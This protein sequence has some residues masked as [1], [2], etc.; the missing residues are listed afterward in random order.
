MK[1]KLIAVL[2][3]IF[4]LHCCLGAC[5]T[6]KGESDVLM[7]SSFSDKSSILED[8][9]SDAEEEDLGTIAI[10][11]G[12]GEV[13]PYVKKAKEYLQAEEGRNVAHYVGSY[14]NP[15]K[16]IELA[17][18]CDAKNVESYTLC[19]GVKGCAEIE[20]TQLDVGKLKNYNLYNLYKGTEYE[21]SVTANLSNGKS[22]SANAN[23]KTTELGPRVMQI[24]GIYNTRDLGGY[25]TSFGKTTKQGLIYRGGALTPYMEGGVVVYPSELTEE[26]KIYMSKTLGI[27]SDLDLRGAGAEAGNLEVSPI[28]GAE[29]Y[30][31]RIGGYGAAFEMTKEFRTVFLLLSDRASYPMYIHCTGGAD[32]T[33]T[34]SFLLNA[35][36][37][38]SEEDLVRD[39]EFTTFSRYGQRNTQE[40]EFA[41]YFQDFIKKLK[42]YEGETLAQKTEA[43]A[44][45][46]G[47]TQEEIDSIREIFLGE[48]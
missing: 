21:W 12:T 15:A 37:G 5:G 32:R 9:F 43:Y 33:G 36:L 27:K 19:Y 10:T 48:N 17:W 28:P 6:G 45:S 24:D 41:G 14:D 31:V 34:V 11:S 7:E 4:S 20:K 26:G 1:K 47:V 13:F 29:L 18:M 16:G 25:A 42:T 30:Y 3:L 44:L 22:I 46:I 35:L 2:C 40:G 8:S 38:V 39:Y 23:F